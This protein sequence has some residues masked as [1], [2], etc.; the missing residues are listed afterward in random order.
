M[1]LDADQ[2]RQAARRIAG[3]RADPGESVACPACG[4]V[5]LE[6]IDR[7]ARPYAEWYVLTCS[8]C[9]LSETLNVPLGPA[10]PSLD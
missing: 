9:G 3:W 8:S 10:V 2:L 7:S 4:K 5:G 6:I 1:P